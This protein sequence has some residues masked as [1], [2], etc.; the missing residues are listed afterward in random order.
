MKWGLVVAGL[1][2][3]GRPAEKL[4]LGQTLCTTLF[5]SLS[6]TRSFSSTHSYRY[7][8][9]SV[10]DTDYPDKLQSDD[11]EPICGRHWSIPAHASYQVGHAPKSLI[12]L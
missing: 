12:Y 3:L 7:H 4:S 9:G 2:D 8:M 10:L 5:H 11:G 6:L 1:A